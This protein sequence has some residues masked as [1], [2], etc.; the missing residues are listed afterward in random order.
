MIT[1]YC[2]KNERHDHG[3]LLWVHLKAVISISGNVKSCD[4]GTF[5][6]ANIA[7][8]S[9]SVISFSLSIARSY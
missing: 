2:A 5:D 6:T 7:L 9:S 4:V 3:L 8:A 1:G